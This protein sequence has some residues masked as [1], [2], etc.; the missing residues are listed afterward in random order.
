MPKIRVIDL[1]PAGF[2]TLTGVITIF[3][4]RMVFSVWILSLGLLL[5]HN[6]F[7]DSL[8]TRFG[9]V[10]VTSVPVVLTAIVFVTAIVM[11]LG[12]G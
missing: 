5:L 12:V 9:P 8:E 3:Q 2:F 10:I 7:A 4:T 11:L 6:A 1:V